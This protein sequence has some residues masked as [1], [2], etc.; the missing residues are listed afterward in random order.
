MSQYMYLA[1]ELQYLS[2]LT[3]VHRAVPPPACSSTSFSDAC[4]N[5]AR[6]TLDTHQLCISYLG[7]QCN[8]FLSSHLNW[9]ILFSPFISFVV[10][11]CHVIETGIAED[12]AKMGNFVQSMESLELG[13]GQVANHHR[14]FEVLYRVS[15][16]YTELKATT[17][18][19]QT[20]N[21]ELISEMDACL[22]SLGY[23]PNREPTVNWEVQT[24]IMGWNRIYNWGIGFH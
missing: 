21:M 2:I 24:S 19:S 5:S 3:L 23:H 8:Q 7:D 15:M 6:S 11:F 14:L 13:S 16:R 10:L 12:L 18:P 22:S 17:T 20:Q 9:V 1:D 4:I